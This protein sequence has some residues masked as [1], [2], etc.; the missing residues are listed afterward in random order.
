MRPAPQ[1]IGGNE[2]D[3][4]LEEHVPEVLK[5]LLATPLPMVPQINAGGVAL[6]RDTERTDPSPKRRS[7]GRMKAVTDC[8]LTQLAS[9]HVQLA[10]HAKAISAV[11]VAIHGT[12]LEGE[13]FPEEGIIHLIR[14]RPSGEAL[15][16][17]GAPPRLQLIAIVN[18]DEAPR[19]RED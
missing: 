7:A 3:N 18:D 14:A 15:V 17:R 4:D 13:G 9:I 10:V 6:R 12:T 19:R 16:L 11:G 2:V 1:G 8:S 5:P